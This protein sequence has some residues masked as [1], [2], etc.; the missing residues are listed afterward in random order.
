MKACKK[1]WEVDE[2]KEEI[3]Q[4]RPRISAFDIY[5]MGWKAALEWAKKQSE[6][7]CPEIPES[8][9]GYIIEE[10]LEQ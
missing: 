4:H 6:N 5:R 7:L 10:E 9:I 1:S 2:T 8:A 3:L